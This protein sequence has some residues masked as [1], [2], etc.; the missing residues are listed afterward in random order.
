[1]P[2][3]RTILAVMLG[4]AVIAVSGCIGGGGN[5]NGGGGN[6]GSDPDVASLSIS[7][8]PASFEHGKY[9]QFTAQGTTS[10]GQQSDVSQQVEWSIQEPDDDV[11]IAQFMPFLPAATVGGMAQGS[12]VLT[13]TL[14][15]LV[16]T[17]DISVTQ[18]DPSAAGRMTL[19]AE[20]NIIVNDGLDKTLIT[21]D[22]EP[23]IRAGNVV[24]DGTLVVFQVTGE[25]LDM[26]PSFVE[27]TVSESVQVTSVASGGT[28]DVG[29]H[30]AVED[31][32]AQEVVLV[33]V[34]D[35]LSK[36]PS[37]FAFSLIDSNTDIV[38]VG[39]TFSI[40]IRN[41]FNRAFTV[42]KYELKN[43]G[44]IVYETSDPAQFGDDGGVIVNGS[45]FAIGYETEVQMSNSGFTGN[46][47]LLDSVT[48]DPFT[49][50]AHF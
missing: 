50:I 47:Q 49:V 8:D 46:F 24:A 21:A 34:T 29:I 44:N 32:T 15:T 48:G 28:G 20:P 45:Q 14:D 4:T 18:G 43:G 12:T 35:D 19:T 30:A 17:T 11:E 1:M 36:A 26:D 39:S 31:T 2:T 3:S 7:P 42:T 23:N 25:S 41:R 6:S 40:S 37:T 33:R 9:R 38:E 16:A 5:S 10:D 22:V 27:Q 13:A